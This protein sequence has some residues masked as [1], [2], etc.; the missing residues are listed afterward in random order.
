MKR[1]AASGISSS[2][3]SA[4]FVDETVWI[5]RGA[6]S[7]AEFAEVSGALSAY[8]FSYE[9]E[10]VVDSSVAARGLALHGPSKLAFAAGSGVRLA[11]TES[12]PA[13]CPKHSLTGLVQAP[14]LAPTG[15][16]ASPAL[17]ARS[18]RCASSTARP[19]TKA[20]R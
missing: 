12:M 3:P 9:P 14:S 4:S 18:C 7:L 2:L 11:Q 10:L 15:R 17:R 20:R 13:T 6:P 5:P 19:G 1:F 16:S 8:A